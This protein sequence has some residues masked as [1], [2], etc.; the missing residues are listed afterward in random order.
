M[1]AKLFRQQT[2]TQP[3][4]RGRRDALYEADPGHCLLE[5]P[6]NSP[7][8]ATSA[9]YTT[10]TLRGGPV[11]LALLGGGAAWAAWRLAGRARGKRSALAVL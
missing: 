7:Q 1:V 5:Q 8:V 9:P 6:G 3:T 10:V 4:L 11:L 2:S